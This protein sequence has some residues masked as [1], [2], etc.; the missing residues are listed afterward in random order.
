MSVFREFIAG[1]DAGIRHQ[2]Q[3]QESPLRQRILSNQAVSGELQSSIDRSQLLMNSIKSLEK[4][5]SDPMERFEI[6]QRLVPELQRFG[7]NISPESFQPED[8]TDENLAQTK[9]ALAGFIPEKDQD[10]TAFERE[11]QSLLSDLEGAVDSQTGRLISPEKMTARQEAAAIK[12]RLIPGA[13]GSAAITAARDPSLGSQVVGF[14]AEK[15]GATEEARLGKR[16]EIEPEVQEKVELAKQRAK[17]LAATEKDE[18]SNDRAL[19][20]Y[21]T[22]LSNLVSAFGQATTGPGFGLIPALTSNQQV[23]DSAIRVMSPILKDVFR[24]AGEGTFTDQ[25][26][27]ALERMIPDRGTRRDAAIQQI[28]QVDDIVQLKLGGDPRSAQEIMGG[29]QQDQKGP[30]VVTT[31]EQFDALPSGTVFIEDG[32]QYRKP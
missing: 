25:D 7:V 31:Q 9:A 30:P 12:L 16:L 21:E 29:G 18:K 3:Q 22:G 2:Q 20:V 32:V 8:L 13:T 15:A 11:R 5:S 28:K 27:I 24:S 23:L 6:A 1:R 4:A 14:E 26:R 10:L 17:N 19:A